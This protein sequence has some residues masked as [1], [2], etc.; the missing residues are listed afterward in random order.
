[1]GADLAITTNR[2]GVSQAPYDTLNLALHVGDVPEAVGENRRRAATAF[3][4]EAGDLVFAEQVHGTSVAEVD[5]ADRGRGF[6]QVGDAIA[7]VD[8]LVT[9]DPSV[10]L[11]TMVADCVPL[12][13]VDPV[14][15]RLASVHAGWRGA[16]A[17]VGEAALDALER[18]GA[19]RSHVVA[20][21]GP[22]VAP[23]RYQVGPDV[24]DAARGRLGAAAEQFLEPDGDQ[25]WR[26]D[27][28]GALRALLVA[29]GVAD[30][31]IVAVP[32]A[33]GPG[34]PFYSDRAAR[35][36]GRFAL[37]ARLHP[38]DEEAPPAT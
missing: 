7:G 19:S 38:Y 25:H 23:A 13:L 35:P 22:S 17:G 1:L 28:A 18:T 12:A 9:A 32:S 8:S 6:D 4:C 14:A 20:V 24:A 5:G 11:A 27:L 29:A 16:L 2:G 10:V 33:T 15:R 21:V 34:S 37:L 26:F 31:R 3:G 36:C 30:D